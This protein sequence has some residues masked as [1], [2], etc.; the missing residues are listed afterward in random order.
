LLRRGVWNKFTDASEVL[1]AIIA[2]T[3]E[4]ASTFETSVN[5]YQTTPRNNPEDSH[6]HNRHRKNLKPRQK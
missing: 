1:S 5:L 2:L 4:A 3:M 6:L